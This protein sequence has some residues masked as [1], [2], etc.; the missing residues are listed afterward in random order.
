MVN[1][2]NEIIQNGQTA[3]PQVR[4]TVEQPVRESRQNDAPILTDHIYMPMTLHVLLSLLTLGIYNYVWIYRMTKYIK[5]HGGDT[6]NMHPVLH[7]IL[8][9]LVPP[10][11]LY[12]VYHYS[13][14]LGKMLGVDS[15]KEI[16]ILQTIV[17]LFGMF[18]SVGLFFIP[19]IMMQYQLNQRYSMALLGSEDKKIHECSACKNLFDE[20]ADTCPKCN[21]V[22]KAPWYTQKWFYIVYGIIGGLIKIFLIDVLLS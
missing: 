19:V 1:E 14:Q 18:S 7:L 4:K 20:E 6:N 9:I 12:W 13:S 15:A 11:K 22:F 2:N 21:T 5:D 3:A 17:T 10:Y 16:A 8:C